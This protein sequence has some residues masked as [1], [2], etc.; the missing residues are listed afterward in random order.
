M[1]KTL[2]SFIYIRFN[3]LNTELEHSRTVKIYEA[4]CHHIKS[5]TRLIKKVLCNSKISYVN[6]YSLYHFAFTTILIIILKSFF[7]NSAYCVEPE[8]KPS[9]PYSH[10]HT[11]LGNGTSICS[12]D[13]YYEGRRYVMVSTPE[14]ITYATLYE[15]SLTPMV[16]ES[17]PLPKDFISGVVR[18]VETSVDH[19]GLGNKRDQYQHIINSA[20]PIIYHIPDTLRSF[21]DNDTY[22]S[23]LI[24]PED[25]LFG[26][27]PYKVLAYI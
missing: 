23:Q 17:S 13:S 12:E 24:I 16:T 2:I 7:E 15:P 27:K 1:F 18:G 11:D 25:P 5:I 8:Y 19:A 21:S 4:L 20:I 9:Y 14:G 10:S 6:Y 22:D 3:K 26:H